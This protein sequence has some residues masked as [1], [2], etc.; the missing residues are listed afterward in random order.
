MIHLGVL[1]DLI[2]S[3]LDHCSLEDAV[4]LAELNYIRVKSTRS[5]LLYCDCLLRLNRR[6][7]VYNILRCHALTNA[8]LRYLFAK[9]CFDL[10][11]KQRSDSAVKQ[12]LRSNSGNIRCV[13]S[14]ATLI[15]SET[16]YASSSN[17][18]QDDLREEHSLAYKDLF[19]SVK[20][21][22][23]VE[24]AIGSYQWDVAKKILGMSSHQFN[25]IS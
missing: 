11:K 7:E 6:Y 22:A 14:S 25:S 23:L 13:T 10:E 3:F 2:R 12:P 21:F 24:D 15:T 16:T 4:F 19:L 20:S 1:Q 5:L 17:T 9:C 18:N 8:R